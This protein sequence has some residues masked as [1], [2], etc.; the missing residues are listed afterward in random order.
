MAKPPKPRTRAEY[1]SESVELMRSA[2]LHVMTVLGD[3]YADV[4]I[5][6]GLVPSL[7]VP[8]PSEGVEAHP[9]TLDLDLGLSL[10]VLEEERYTK[11]AE[12]L[13]S[14]GFAPAKYE[15]GRAMRQTW[16]F[17]SGTGRVLVDFLIGVASDE[18]KPGRLQNLQANFAAFIVE[19]VPL[20]FR[21]K[22]SISISGRTLSDSAPRLT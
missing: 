9:G 20:A 3:L 17:G 22:R 15:D 1:A 13:R 7:L 12:R 2:A 19:G 18:S 6:G 5:V 8:S 14:A 10:G 16:Q 11:I 4:V 21:D